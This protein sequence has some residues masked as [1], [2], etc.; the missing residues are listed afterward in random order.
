MKFNIAHP[1]Q[2]HSFRAA[3][4]LH[5]MG[6]L[7][8]YMTTV[9]KK[10]NSVTSFIQRFLSS[11]D[12]I[13][14]SRRVNST[15]PENKVIQYYEL[16]ALFTI[17]LSRFPSLVK[18]KDKWNYII[19]T[20]FNKKVISVSSKQDIHG[21]IV[22]DGTSCRYL[23]RLKQKRPSIVTIADYSI[24]SRPFMRKLFEDDMQKFS[25]KDFYKEDP[26]LWN[27]KIIANVM[28]DIAST[29]YFLVA[30]NFVKRSLQYCGVTDDRIR[31]LPYG[32]DVEKFKPISKN[33]SS[34]VL[35]LLFVGQLNR[36]KGLHHLLKVVRDLKQDVELTLAGRIMPDSDLY[37]EYKNDLNIHFIGFVDSNNLQNVYHNKDVFVLPSLAEGMSLAGLEAMALGMPILCSD[38]TGI[39]D[40][41]ENGINGFVFKTGDLEDLKQ[42]IQWFL[43]HRNLLKDMGLKSRH[44]AEDHSWDRYYTEFAKI[45]NE[46]T[47]NND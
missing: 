14:S 28:S 21:L 6:R 24:A 45:I 36:R 42:K 47:S 5:K 19:A 4:A 27:D 22:Y 44:I 25:H 33:S 38:N 2:Q 3:I 7:G 23:K 34:S 8:N 40:L 15:I 18:I 12:R 11:K 30:S 13:K 29:D 20:R 37:N 16:S 46:I 35:S 17:F 43:S 41:V 10:K 31:I 26:S 39:N 32:V 1:G 9:Y